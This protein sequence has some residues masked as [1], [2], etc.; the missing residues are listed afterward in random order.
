MGV[1]CTDVRAGVTGAAGSSLDAPDDAHTETHSAL[2]G[3][4]ED[5]DVVALRFFTIATCCYL[6]ILSVVTYYSFLKCCPSVTFPVNCTAY[7]KK[8]LKSIMK[9]G[10]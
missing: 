9:Y 5:Y 4:T 7:Y 3:W 6:T 2:F 8:L 10:E 1:C